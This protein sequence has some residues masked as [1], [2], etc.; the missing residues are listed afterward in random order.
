MKRKSSK[1]LKAI[2]FGTAFSLAFS[3]FVYVN[4]NATS[5]NVE[6]GHVWS[7]DKDYKSQKYLE[8]LVLDRNRKLNDL[9]GIQ[10]IEDYISD[11]RSLYDL[12]LLNNKVEEVEKIMT[13]YERNQV[14][15]ELLLLTGDNNLAE[16]YRNDNEFNFKFE[17]VI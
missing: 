8:S 10:N 4:V 2:S 5:V 9:L 7:E 1:I 14:Y 16:K 12:S 11:M 3:A 6:S 15:Y 17:R 13:D